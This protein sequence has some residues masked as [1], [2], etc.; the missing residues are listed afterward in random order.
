MSGVAGGRRIL[1]KEIIPLYNKYIMVFL[2]Q[3]PGFKRACLA[4][5]AAIREKD[6]YGDLDIIVLFEGTNKK[7]VKK[8]II[9]QVENSHLLD[10]F[11]SEKHSNKKYYNAGELI[12]VLFEDVQIDNII[13]LSEEE[14]KFKQC[15]LDMPAEIQGL[16]LGMVKTIGIEPSIHDI[17]E[18]LDIQTVMMGENQEYQFTLSS[19]KIILE[20][21][22]LDGN[23]DITDKQ[24]LWESQNWKDVETVLFEYDINAGFLEF[25]LD[26]HNQLQNPR[27]KRRV[28]GVFNSMVTIKSGEIGTEKA[29]TK[30]YALDAVNTILGE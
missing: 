19:S 29:K 7:E 10:F 26:I 25:L 3:I 2:S 16:V 17:L 6:S 11:K 13:A 1:T 22:T 27:S 9:S 12:S 8:Q 21:V 14:M 30:K 28:K 24:L 20:K 23:Y 18:K 15:F 5:S 4:G